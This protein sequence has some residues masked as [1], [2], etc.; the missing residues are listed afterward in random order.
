MTRRFLLKVLGAVLVVPRWFTARAAATA[1]ARAAQVG[2]PFSAAEL[3][4]LNGIAEVALPSALTAEDRR[5]AVR[6]FTSWFANYREG[7]DRGHGYGSSTLRSPTGPSPISRYPPQFEALD[8]AAAAR[9]AAT[10][11]ALPQAAR[12]EIVEAALNTPQRVT[13]LPA[14]PTGANLVADVM[15]IW[16]NSQDGW[17]L[18]YRA[19]IN[20]DSCRTLDNSLEPPRAIGG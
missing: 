12:R 13:R 20:R 16:F 18:A 5:L 2:A 15:G 6:A 19:D 3:A 8:A 11:A 9:G 1:G 7:A 4:T 17:N 14:Q 10:F